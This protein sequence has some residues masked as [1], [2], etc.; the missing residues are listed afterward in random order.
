M[1]GIGHRLKLRLF[2]EGVEVPVISASVQVTPN[3]P[4]A[5]SIQ[6]PPLPT[7]LKFLPRTLVHLF[8]YDMYQAAGPF[9]T[10][11]GARDVRKDRQP[12]DTER[13]TISTITIES[14][15]PGGPTPPSIDP[16]QITV[17]AKDLEDGRYKLLF[18]GEV[19]GQ[20]WTKNESQRSL[21]LQCMDWSNYWDYAYQW[22]N[23]DLFG[24]GVK[25][26]FSGGST[27]LF[28]DFLEDEGSAIIRIIQTPSVQF[29]KLKGLLGGIAHLLEAIGG[30][31]YSGKAFAGENIFFSLAELRLHVTQ[32]ITA[33]EDDPTA[34]RLLS[35]GYDS[36]LGR[37][38]G[39]LGQQVS[40]RQA[41]NALMG[42]IFHETYA[43]PCPMYAPG[44]G[45]T[46][47]GVTRVPLSQDTRFSYIASAAQDLV[48]GIS[49]LLDTLSANSASTSGAPQPASMVSD[50]SGMQSLIRSV[51]NQITDPSVRQARAFYTSALR[52]LGQAQAKVATWRPGATP[53]VVSATST[54][55]TQ[56][57]AELM[58]VTAMET[59]QQPASVM[60]AR[61]NQQ[62][63]RPDVWFSA[64]PRCNVLFPEL[65]H[66]MSFAQQFLAEPTRLLLKTNDEFFGEDELFDQFYFAPKGFTLKTGG[67][68]LQNILSNDL[69]QHELFTGIL[70]VF[71]KMGELNIFAARSGSSD[72]SLAKVGLAQRSTNFLYFK[73]RFAARQMQ[74]KGKFNPWVAVGFPGLV[75]DKYIDPASVS[76]M[77]TLIAQQGGTTSD[78]NDLLG[79][80]FLANFTEVTHTV[81]QQQGTTDY[82]CSYARQHNESV[83]FLGVLRPDQTVHRRFP[84]DAARA[85]VIA[86]VDAPAI[87]SLG[88]NLGPI[89]AVE[90]VTA[91]NAAK[92]IASG[93]KFPVLA[94]PSRSGT[95]TPSISV[96]VG[97]TAK[98]SDFGADV[99]TFIGDP[100]A[101]VTFRA[102]RV[103]ESVPRYRKDTVDLPAEE[104]IRPGWYGDI[105]HPLLIGQ[106]YTQFFN[107][108]AITD[109]Q[110]VSDTSGGSFGVS[111]EDAQQ[112][113][114][115]AASATDADDPLTNAPALLALD[116]N[117]TIADA[118]SFIVQTYSATR[119]RGLDVDEYIRGY[120]W[121]PIATL[122]DLFGTRD[123]TLDDQGHQVINGIE[124]F[125]SR[126]FGPYE[127]LFG[128]TTPDIENIVGIVR[129]SAIAARGDTRKR[130]QDAVKAYVAAIQYARAI[131]G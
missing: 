127:D 100:T 76:A 97:I 115:T 114:A 7:G 87:N 98:A 78:I 86:A 6:I 39:D 23:T 92:D 58:R 130:K 12:T 24:P 91:A 68:E 5:C 96:P 83:E 102:F 37:T 59:V 55:L 25:A 27:N 34:S 4:A 106:A 20:Q 41:I 77:Q 31:Y 93:R 46:P 38:L 84:T 26:L 42:I 113:L 69:L 124:G 43:Q 117:A 16:T 3:A 123:L 108:G 53:T 10:T 104:Y 116:K 44:S 125:H 81:D 95:R 119:A 45:D 63:F 88:P 35:A 101:L 128:L 109:Q 18:G 56:A 66:S 30:S 118:V 73:Y 29:P 131:L 14:D 2:L 67:K 21:V 90:D 129:G 121:R 70:P 13:N 48:L 65:Y 103:T 61:L 64:P 79:V 120:T 33:Y 22:N 49:G 99:A 9:S 62:I 60:P 8:F 19:V 94:G 82:N 17:N 110:Q 111:Y 51:V 80:H 1:A 28:T 126:A 74:V 85:T 75:I 122:T 54:Y 15:G 11:S 105:W 36:L 72:G 89:I 50:L 112:A 47:A 107:T 52:L 32:L 71:E 57:Q 40:I